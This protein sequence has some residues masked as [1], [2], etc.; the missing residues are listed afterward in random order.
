MKKRPVTKAHDGLHATAAQL[1]VM[2]AHVVANPPAEVN[3]GGVELSRMYVDGV[4]A[5]AKGRGYSQT[6]ALRLMLAS[7]QTSARLVE[8]SRAAC[9]AAGTATINRLIARMSA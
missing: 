4:L 9:R 2:S 7:G 8:M 3:A 6:D 1:L 5:G